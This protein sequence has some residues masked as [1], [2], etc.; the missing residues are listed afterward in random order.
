MAK[1]EVVEME[2]AK[3]EIVAP[4]NG[5][6]IIDPEDID[7]PRVNLVQKM[8]QIDGPLGAIM[9]DQKHVLAEA[10]TAIPVSIVAARKGWRE[11]IPYDDDEMPRMVWTHEERDALEAESGYKILEFADIR[12]LF[13]GGKDADEM[14]FN[15]PIGDEQYSLGRIN[16]QKDAYRNT[17]KRLATFAAVNAGADMTTKVWNLKSILLTKGKYSWYAPSL[18]NSPAKASNEVVQFLSMLQA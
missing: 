9:L 3:Q 5:G 8:S 6:L 16:V 4:N 13:H 15:V 1:Q 10:D 12:L 2:E 18:E 11:D 17:Y 7:I 14:I